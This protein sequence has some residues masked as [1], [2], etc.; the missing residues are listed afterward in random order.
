MVAAVLSHQGGKWVR[1][2]GPAWPRALPLEPCGLLASLAPALVRP[3][4]QHCSWLKLRGA[5]SLPTVASTGGCGARPGA[6]GQAAWSEAAWG[7]A[8]VTG[9]EPRGGGGAVRTLLALCPGV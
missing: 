3:V 1:V 7:L 9:P 6:C 4:G 2:L 5:G 8:D